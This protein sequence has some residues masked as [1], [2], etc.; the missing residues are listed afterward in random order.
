MAV[1]LPNDCLDSDIMTATQ[2]LQSGRYSEAASVCH[3]VL[4]TAPNQPD[5]LRLL[6][7]IAHVEG[8]R[9]LAGSMLAR[10]MDAA[11]NRADILNDF[12]LE[13]MAQRKF[14]AAIQVFDKA[15]QL[16]RLM[17][18]ALYNKGLAEKSINRIEA[19]LDSFEAALTLDPGFFKAHF[20]IGDLLLTQGRHDAATL[21]F[22]KALKINPGYI[23]AYNHL[24]ISLSEREHLNEAMQWLSK[25]HEIDPQCADTLCNMGNLMRKMRRFGDAE[26]MY[27][28][29][30]ARRADFIEAHFNL[31]IVL[32]LLRKF[33]EGWQ[34]YEWRLKHFHPGSGYP[35]RHGLPLW[36]GQSLSGKAILIYD[37][38][39][40]GD[41]LMACRFLKK[42]KSMNATV[43][44]EVRR[45]LF[46]FFMHFEWADEVVLRQATV[47]PRIAC[48]YCL[49]LLSL[50]HRFNLKMDGIRGQKPYLIAD[51]G[52]TADWSRH[53]TGPG[54][55]I[56]LVWRGSIA[57]PARKLDVD[58]LSLLLPKKTGIT[59]YSLQKEDSNGR[60]PDGMP[61]WLT[62]LG[63]RLSDFTE[64]AAAIANLDLVISI[65]TAVAHLAGA[66]GKP[67]WVLLPFVPDWRWFLDTPDT[68]WYASMRLFRQVEPG[69]WQK[70]LMD[71]CKALQSWIDVR[72]ADNSVD[73]GI[74][75]LLLKAAACRRKGEHHEAQEIY[76][77]IL[78]A[79]PDCYEAFFSLGLLNLE[80]ASYPEAIVSFEQALCIKPGDHLSLNNLGL[81]YHRSGQFESAEAAFKKAI[82]ARSDFITA[83]CNLGNLYL[84]LEDLDSTIAWYGRA[85]ELNP[86]DARAQCEMG[87]LYLKTLDLTSALV[88]FH[89][90]VDLDSQCADAAISMATTTLLKGD[91][92]EGWKYYRHR[93]RYKSSRDQ[94]FPYQYRLTLW[95]GETFAKKKLI[96]HSEQGFGDAIQFSRFLPAVKA[97][98]GHVTYQV[99]PVLMPLFQNF[100]GVDILEPM[101]QLPPDNP[102]ADLYVP[103]M[104]IPAC[105]DITLDKIPAPQPYLASDPQKLKTWRSCINA[106]KF[107]VGLA[108]AGNAQHSNDRNRSCDL[109]NLIDLIHMEDVQFY[110]LQKDI[111]PTDFSVMKNESSI[112]DLGSGFHDFGD[113][114]AA[115]DCLDLVISVDTAVAHL[116]GAMAKPVWVL[117]PFLPDWRWM[118]Y[119]SDSPWYPSMRLFRQLRAGDWAAVI[120]NLKQQLERLL[121]R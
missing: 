6:G 34:E 46:E 75:A 77:Q 11:P 68:P 43:V 59:W 27:R 78:T 119:R 85:L 73:A 109:K 38:Q 70:P 41:I 8:D 111:N 40:F 10:A 97:R 5:A 32:L 52:K 90:A 116:A 45:E 103:L 105:L 61:D 95:Q 63:D 44:F 106:S 83:Y 12:G 4:K 33:N 54:L 51:P 39:G 87:K 31:A 107:K 112:I 94:A 120:R 89:K 67:V 53:I 26:K 82:I 62:P 114:A 21:H 110:N 29:A 1:I 118:L 108:W 115:I 47:K 24:A 113:T 55:K 16:Q 79:A 100:P 92:P 49:P 42:L 69:N 15:H 81:A 23:A 3:G 36:A 2:L 60:S 14:R 35:C 99:Q 71:I 13:L 25:A 37:E 72:P 117:L 121:C 28:S 96:V 7:L 20:C 66:L 86:G 64:T 101:P 88:H 19:A 57:D 80:S 56:G 48:D 76:G 22:L 102:D 74:D 91:L 84:D 104:D 30:I 9:Q 50:P 18:H 17:P 58:Q 93:F 98:G 65:D